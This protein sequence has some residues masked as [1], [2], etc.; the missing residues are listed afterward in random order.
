ME[1][2]NAKRNKKA[3]KAKEK[4]DKFGGFST[5]HIRIQEALQAKKPKAPKQ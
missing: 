3:D 4:R 5:K 1:P 2:P